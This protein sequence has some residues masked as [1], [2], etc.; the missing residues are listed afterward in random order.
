MIRISPRKEISL[1]RAL[2]GL[3]NERCVVAATYPVDEFWP[4]EISCSNSPGFVEQNFSP[5]PRRVENRCFRWIIRLWR[6]LGYNPGTAFSPQLP[7]SST[8]RWGALK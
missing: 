2:H 6:E 7:P 3:Q 1:E 4:L 5:H 8:G